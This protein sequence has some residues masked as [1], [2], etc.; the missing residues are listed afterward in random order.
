MAE[1]S[2]NTSIVSLRERVTWARIPA[3][4]PPTDMPMYEYKIPVPAFKGS[5]APRALPNSGD[6]VI[7]TPTTYHKGAPIKIQY[8][9]FLNRFQLLK[10]IKKF[11]FDMSVFSTFLYMPD[12]NVPIRSKSSTIPRPPPTK[13][14]FRQPY[15]ATITAAPA[16]KRPITATIVVP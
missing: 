11:P 10:S 7:N 14:A 12:S 9:Y 15:F 13:Y 2:K 16:P 4:M 6:R 5:A 3:N 8:R 1:S